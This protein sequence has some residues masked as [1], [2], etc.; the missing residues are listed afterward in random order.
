M[1]QD[2]S[3]PHPQARLRALHQ[4]PGLWEQFLP[5]LWQFLPQLWG[6]VLGEGMW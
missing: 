6:R 1:V 2:Q 5:L 4:L 3:L